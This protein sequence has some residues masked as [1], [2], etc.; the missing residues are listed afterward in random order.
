MNRIVAEDRRAVVEGLT[1]EE[2]CRFQGGSVLITGGAGFLGFTL[3]GAL[4]E[5]REALGIRELVCLDRFDGGVP[6]W[7]EALAGEGNVRLY[8]FDI[9]KDELNS[10]PE[11]DGADFVIHMA[12]IASPVFYRQH[13][14]ETMDANVGGLRKLLDYYCGRPLRG[15]AFFSSSE[16]YGDPA[17]EWIPTPESYRG[18]VDCQGPRACYDEAKRLG[19]TLCYLFSRQYGMPITVIRS[20]NNYGP[21]M[22]FDDARIAAD[23][24]D[25]VLKNRDIRIFSDG[26][27]TRSFCYVSDAT[28]GY[29][30]CLLHAGEGFE[31]YNIGNDGPEI[32]VR[33]MAE[34]FRQ[35]GEELF[36]YSGGIHF[37]VHEDPAYL[38]NNP[39]RRCPSI[40][41]ARE[42]LG[43]QPMTPLDA[44]L[45]R[46]LLSA[47]ENER[48]PLW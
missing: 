22:R 32:S 21:G 16:V 19:E 41:K 30:K 5:Y 28:A 2:R 8:P 10:V 12:S 31:T 44:G 13:P 48:N 36:A 4:A 24:T 14:I 23:F 45:R 29:L 20:F 43:Y 46:T 47:R 35:A 38:K 42:K 6:P 26:S 37:A 9:V 15:F 25:A 18:N 39:N 11:A 40:Q 33:E 3:T 1:E 17:P 27:P 7:L 34:R